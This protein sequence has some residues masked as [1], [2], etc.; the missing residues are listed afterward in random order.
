EVVPPSAKLCLAFH[1]Q[2][3]DQTL[4]SLC[5]C[6]VG[7]VSFVLVELARRKEATRR[8]KHLV[9]LIDDGGLAD[10]GIAGDQN[11]LGGAAHHDPVKAG[12]QGYDL[13]LTPVELFGDQKPVRRVVSAKREVV[14]PAVRLPR[15]K[16]PTQVTLQTGGGLVAI[17]G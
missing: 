4:K 16:T 15:C 5:R 1:Q 10:A 7:N 14:D 3:P 11:Q 2:R 12:E 17:L 6:R 13:P 9:E 8:N